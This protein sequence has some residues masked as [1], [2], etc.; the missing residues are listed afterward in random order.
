[1]LEVRRKKQEEAMRMY[2]EARKRA[3][4][5]VDGVRGDKGDVAVGGG[6]GTSTGYGGIA[7]GSGSGAMPSAGAGT[8]AS[9][10]EVG[11]PETVRPVDK[12]GY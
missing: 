6:A 10:G 3:E 12:V 2:E 7:S 1:M 9:N 5:I 11:R 8:G 4:R